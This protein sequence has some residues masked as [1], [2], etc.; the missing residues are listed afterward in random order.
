MVGGGSLFIYIR[1]AFPE[2]KVKINDI[3][4]NVYCFWKFA[5]KVNEEL[6]EKIKKIKKRHRNG[7]NLYKKLISEQKYNDLAEFDRAVN[8]FILNRITFSGLT[9]SG[10]FSSEAFEKRF[11]DSS[12]ERLSL[13]E[14]IMKGVDV[15]CNDYSQLL[16][17]TKK[18]IFVYLDPPYLSSK[19]SKLYG[20]NGDLHY[21]FDHQRFLEQ[22]INCKH[23]LLITYDNSKLIWDFYNK[24]DNIH[25]NPLGLQYGMNNV[26]KNNIPKSKELIITNYE[27]DEKYLIT[28]YI[29]FEI[30]NEVNV[31]KSRKLLQNVVYNKIKK[32]NIKL[33]FNYNNYFQKVIN[34]L[35]DNQFIELS[36]RKNYGKIIKKTSYWKLDIVFNL[37]IKN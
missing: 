26:H 22:V 32:H 10:G 17:G 29:L 19:E 27:I 21:N 9:T 31:W 11:T 23:N 3:N 7:K 1:Q 25:L 28:L 5:K 16:N 4:K 37:L 20:H 8:F 34:I 2:I 13:I 24:K 12:I 33:Y 36:E 30:E 6:V 18:G 14:D 35:N 15:S